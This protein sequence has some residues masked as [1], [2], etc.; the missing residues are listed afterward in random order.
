MS[1]LNMSTIFNSV[2]KIETSK[3]I[4]LV[5]DMLKEQRTKLDRKN[6]SNFNLGQEV[7]FMSDGGKYNGTVDSIGRT[8]RVKVKLIG[9]FKYDQY[10]LGASSLLEGLVN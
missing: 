8:G 3:N 7:T 9:H 10:T 5:Y 1:D 4:D 2:A 6:S